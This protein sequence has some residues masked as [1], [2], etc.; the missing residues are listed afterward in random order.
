MQSETKSAHDTRQSSL[1][2][3]MSARWYRMKVWSG[4]WDGSSAEKNSRRSDS[5]RK[6]E[7]K[8]ALDGTIRSSESCSESIACFF[9]FFIEF[10]SFSFAESLCF[11]YMMLSDWGASAVDS[12]P[13]RVFLSR[14]A[15]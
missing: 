7:S 10:T 12:G 15:E 4:F 6:S 9:P 14:P 8:S 11:L 3:P 5:V 1:L 2:L 13:L